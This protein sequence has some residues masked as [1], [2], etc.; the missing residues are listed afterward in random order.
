MTTLLDHNGNP[1]DMAA[2]RSELAAQAAEPQTSRVAN[3]WREFDAHPS[4]GLTPA[5]LRALL[6]NGERGDLSIQ[7]D[8]ADDMEEMDPHLFSEL[9]KRK[10]AVA[11]LDWSIEPPENATAAEEALAAEVQEWFAEL[12][13]NALILDALDGV[14]K[15]YSCHEL[16]WS[17]QE[18]VLL[19]RA[20]HRPGRWFTVDGTRNRLLL[21]NPE[22]DPTA[23]NQAGMFVDPAK[24]PKPL[25][26]WEKLAQVL[27]LSNEFAFVD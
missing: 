18:S 5:K 20:T 22:A 21:R 8:L 15:G 24:L 10:G 7:C 26:A 11:L 27:L 9:D 16:V 2:V 1:I 12:D 25:G 14:M 19:P 6:V 3:I 13:V 17:L 4:R 23:A